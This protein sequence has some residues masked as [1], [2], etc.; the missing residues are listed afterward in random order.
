MV[1]IYF[2]VLPIWMPEWLHNSN[3]HKEEDFW[4]LCVWISNRFFRQNINTLAMKPSGD[5]ITNHHIDWC[6]SNRAKLEMNEEKKLFGSLTRHRFICALL[7][8]WCQSH[9]R[10]TKNKGRQKCYLVTKW[11]AFVTPLTWHCLVF[12]RFA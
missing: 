5:C 9:E 4:H 8:L 3:N 2:D 6:S 11:K 1:I 7:C 10:H 12:K